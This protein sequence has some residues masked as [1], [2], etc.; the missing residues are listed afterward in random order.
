MKKEKANLTD[1]EEKII[2]ADRQINEI[3]QPVR[4]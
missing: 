4:R 1:E 2:P 3:Q